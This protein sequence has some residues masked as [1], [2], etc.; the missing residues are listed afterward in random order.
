MR[1][2]CKYAIVFIL[3]LI[4]FTLACNRDSAEPP[5]LSPPLPPPP[6]ESP[7]LDTTPPETI[8]TSAP[9]VTIDLNEVI[10]EWTGNDETTLPADLTYSYYLEGYETEYSPFVINT[11]R[12]YTDLQDGSYI[13]HV[14]SQDEAGNIDPTPSTSEFIIA[15]TPQE[16]GEIN[17]PIDSR[18]LIAPG[19]DV[20]RIAVGYD[21]KT[22]YA[23]D[24]VN[25]QIYK[26]EQGGY[27]WLNISRGIAGVTTCDD[28]AVAPDNFDIVA[29]VAN[30]GSEVYLSLDGGANF[31]VTQL[32]GTIGAGEQVKCLDISPS[33]GRSSWEL[34]V[35]TST[36]SGG[37]RV[38]VNMLNG[39]PSGWKD[40]S[41][42]SAGWLSASVSKTDVFAIEY[43]PGFASDST[44]LAIVA[45]GAAPDSD[46]TYLYAGIRDLASSDTTWNSFAG[47][48]VEICQSGQDTPG[49]SLTY[50]DLA[51]PADYVGT[52]PSRRHVY[53]CWTDNPPGM[54]TAGNS[55]DDV[56][57]IDDAVCYRLQARPDVICSLAHYGMYSHGKL[58]AGAMV[59]GT[60]TFGSSTQTYFTANPQSASPTWKNSQKP[61][62]GPG[63]AM[64]AWSPDGKVAYCGTSSIGGTNHDQSA[65][66]ISANDGFTW[67]QIGLIDT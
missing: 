63:Q 65:F 52:V 23:I 32:A 59:S 26:S 55:N 21:G 4:T 36:G 17:P 64:V 35:G 38:L 41:S 16:E 18:L 56:Y 53:A 15:A 51:L 62:T 27:G 13:F 48:P 5:V 10:F 1:L 43:A 6:A 3:Y 12:S 19:S 58:L 44:L 20:S 24:S 45:S 33:Y 67:N 14:R 57:R 25:A 46:D 61:P 49:T 9:G 29:L 34:A 39:F 50:A 54:A 31:N 37:G 28:L 40:I 42:G 7:P 30:A 11:S 2:T 47:Y 60:T 22:I 66:S 8:I